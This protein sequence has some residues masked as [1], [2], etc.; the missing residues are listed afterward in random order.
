M[1]WCGWN[2]ASEWK[3]KGWYMKILKHSNSEVY[4]VKVA[5]SRGNET[6]F[7]T[8][9]AEKN[10]SLTKNKCIPFGLENC[11]T[12]FE[13]DDDENRLVIYKIGLF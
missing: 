11:V 9:W 4:L 3:M 13:E 1:K 5:I 6:I 2:E 12:A 8:D 10:K 7:Y